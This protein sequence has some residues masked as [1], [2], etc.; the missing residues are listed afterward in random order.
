MPGEPHENGCAEALVKGAKKAL[1][2]AIGE[3]PDPI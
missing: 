1:K 3:R 2:R